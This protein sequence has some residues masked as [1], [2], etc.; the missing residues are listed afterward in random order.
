M[1]P[2]CGPINGLLLVT[3]VA[4]RIYI[5]VITDHQHH[6]QPIIYLDRHRWEA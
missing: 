2:F 3:S 4:F 1:R 5:I 6:Q